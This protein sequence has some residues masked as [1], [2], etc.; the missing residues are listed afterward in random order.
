MKMNQKQSGSKNI[1]KATI[2]STIW[3]VLQTAIYLPSTVN[4]SS[5][6]IRLFFALLAGICLASSIV[7]AILSGHSSNGYSWVKFGLIYIIIYFVLFTL[8]SALFT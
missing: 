2:F 1:V 8:V 5:P 3:F 7:V 6:E 4:K